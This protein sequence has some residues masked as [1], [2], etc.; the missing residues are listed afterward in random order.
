ME[1]DF[2]QMYLEELEQIVPCTKQEE[3]LLLEQ[4]GQGREDAK[5]RLIEG[6]LK[7][8][9]EYAREYENKGLSMGD[10][11]QEANMAL[12]LAAGSFTDGD[13]QD[14]L[15]TEI[16]KAVEAAIEEQLAENRTE[17]EIAARVNVLQKVSQIMAKELGRE[18]TVEE[19]A[20]RMK[21]TEDEIKEIMKI[22]LDAVNV[23]Q[24]GRGVEDEQE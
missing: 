6:N 20:G 17:E 7:Q 10:L 22:T 3:I 19:L 18:A 11:V 12:T 2:Y 15:E 16:R 9:L 4:L 24:A 14:Y 8:A 21:M 1:H 13:F 5:A 23:M